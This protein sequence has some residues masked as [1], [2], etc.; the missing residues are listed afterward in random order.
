VTVINFSKHVFTLQYRSGE[1]V[2]PENELQGP[3]SEKSDR[4][5]SFFEK[6]GNKK[7]NREF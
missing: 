1:I 3:T 5:G 7:A 2:F 6:V 4:F